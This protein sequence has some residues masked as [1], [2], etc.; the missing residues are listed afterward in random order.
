MKYELIPESGG[1][2]KFG[3]GMGIRRAIKVLI[4]NATLSIQ[5]ERRKYWSKGLFGGED[6][7]SD[8]NYIMRDQ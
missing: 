2:G 4:D 3:G 8:K 6:R 5:S 7:R 1:N